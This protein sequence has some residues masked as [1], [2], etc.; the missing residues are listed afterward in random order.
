MQNI[1]KGY[2]NSFEREINS[3]IR[4]KLQKIVKMD[5][6][7]ISFLTQHYSQEAVNSLK[8]LSGGGSSRKYYRFFEQ[9]ESYILSESSNV[10]ENKTFFYFTDVLNKT[11]PNIP[12]IEYI[13][14]DN[15]LYIQTDLGDSTLMNVIENNFEEAKEYYLESI[16]LLVKAQ[17]EAGKTID[18]TQTFSYPKLDKTLILR[19][20]F[21]FKFYF[22]NVLGI[23]FNQGKLIKDFDLFASQFDQLSPKGF[24]FRD[25]QSRNIMIKNNHPYFIDYQGGLYGPIFY[26]LVSLIWQAKANL[27]ADFKNNLYDFYLQ[28]LQKLDETIVP[29]DCRRSY[30]YC[31]VAR[32]IQVLGAYGL[33]GL[34][35]RKSHFIESISFGL[36]NLKSIIDYPIL[37]NYPELKH[38]ITVLIQPQTIEKIN[39]KING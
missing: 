20:L 24:V 33:R 29:I 19:D 5:S 6:K 25:F 10:E 32:L 31:V 26:D 39:N 38:I 21:Q 3:K 18:F 1:K 12:K 30:E 27:S 35:E 36:D 28:E 7:I 14:D 17:I 16:K 34:I 23:D 15:T 9:N 11:L 22:L 8:L 4:C 37:Q 2:K 13:S